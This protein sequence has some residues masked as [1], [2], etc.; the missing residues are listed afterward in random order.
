MANVDWM[1]GIGPKWTQEERMGQIR[2]N[3]TLVDRMD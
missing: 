1:D 2:P 3:R